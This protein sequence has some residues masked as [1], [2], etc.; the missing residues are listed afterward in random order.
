MLI[1]ITGGI[2]SGKSTISH[3]LKSKGYIVIDADKLGHLV[4]QEEAFDEVLT[5]FGEKILS[6]DQVIDRQKLASVVFSNPDE[7]QKLNRICWF[8]IGKRIEQQVSESRLCF[9]EA[10]LLVEAGWHH[11]CQEVWLVDASVEQV[12][13]RIKRRNQWTETEVLQRIHSQSTFEERQRFATHIIDNR[14][15]VQ[16]LT[17]QVDALLSNL[18]K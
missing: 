16:H 15:S 5:Q 7:L 1:G 8:Y 14:Q 10:A 18:P 6:Q 9:L 3:Y 11:K 4:L 17:S 13:L 12:I 2:G